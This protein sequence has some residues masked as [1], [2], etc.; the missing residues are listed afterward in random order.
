MKK[1]IFILL[2]L[3]SLGLFAQE[4]KSRNAPKKKLVTI[5]TSGKDYWIAFLRNSAANSDESMDLRII[6]NSEK[7]NKV[8][9]SND[10]LNLNEEYSILAN[11]FVDIKVSHKFHMI[12]KEGI[13]N[14]AIHLTAEND[15]SIIVVNSKCSSSDTYYAY[16]TESLGKSYHLV[17]FGSGGQ[18]TY[19]SEFGVIATEDSTILE[20]TPTRSTNWFKKGKISRITLKKGQV[21]LSNS[22]STAEL[23]ID[24]T[25][26]L[27]SANKK[28]ALLS[29]HESLWVPENF[30]NSNY[31]C[32]QMVPDSS[33]GMNFIVPKFELRRDYIVRVMSIADSNDIYIGANKIKLNNS[34]FK[35]FRLN[36]DIEIIS[37][38]PVAV[39]Q[40]CTSYYRNTA[41]TVG[42][43]MMLA[44]IPNQLF[45]Q[46]YSFKTPNNFDYHFL[47]IVAS[48][49]NRKKILF[50]GLPLSDKIFVDLPQSK[51]TIARIKIREGNHKLESANN[52]GLYCYG[53][54]CSKS[55]EQTDAYGNIA[56]M[57]FATFNDLPDTLAPIAELLTNPNDTINKAYIV[58][59]DKYDCDKG[60]KEIQTLSNKGLK[61]DSPVFESGS[62]RVTFEINPID[63][64]KSGKYSF[65]L[66]DLANNTSYFTICYVYDEKLKKYI[67][68]LNSGKNQNCPVDWEYRVGAYVSENI[69]Y[70]SLGFSSTGEIK[71]KGSFSSPI[72]I[73]NNFGFNFSKRMNRI[74]NLTANL[75]IFKFNGEYNSPDDT[76]TK[77]ELPNGSLGN[78]QQM[79]TFKM[80]S[81][82]L[83]L[84]LLAE[85]NLTKK[86]YWT[87]G[88]ITI[89]PISKSINSFKRI[90][91][92]EDFYY[93]NGT[94]KTSDGMPDKLTSISVIRFGA[95][96]GLGYNAQ[97]N[98]NYLVFGD[99]RYN[100]YFTS[101]VNDGFWK[102]G[103]ISGILG[104]KYNLR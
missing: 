37:E 93:P 72:N 17:S 104:I 62:K 91:L 26:T 78:Y 103:Q 28:I 8:K 88:L 65:E 61:F 38:R 98:N 1:I 30:G 7:A 99:I 95:G 45:K 56:G 87:A 9:I 90:T 47:S 85:F 69:N 59:S 75:S 58:I 57:N 68:I 46:S 20:I 34:E 84:D 6:V 49:E 97:I 64:N 40:Y 35:D 44:I 43:P 32:E 15:V 24:L 3:S 10:S 11:G 23:N 70:H 19:R 18:T 89:M 52:F 48:R 96:L 74:Y 22:S 4:G 80:E 60:L 86:I 39:M 100:Y 51:Y 16:C 73:N 42:D 92:P 77:I 54:D 102:I 55:K 101:V 53:Y 2:F 50:D 33:L 13:Y 83:Q 67:F 66:R 36:S 79:V 31:V 5:P 94:R 63:I 29:G 25:G 21:L 41:D 81:Y 14:Q 12:G 71:S 76:L 27:I 82:Q